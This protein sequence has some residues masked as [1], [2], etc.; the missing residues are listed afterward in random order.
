MA[1]RRSAFLSG[2]LIAVAALAAGMVLASRLD[3]APASFAGAVDVPATNSAPLDGPLDASTFRTIAAQVGPAV[4]SIQ[5]TGRRQ[6]PPTGLEEFFGVPNPF[7]EQDRGQGQGQP[8]V[9]AGSGFIIDADGY[10]LTNRHVI[11]G[12]DTIEVFLSDMDPTTNQPGLPAEVVGQDELVDT[13]LLRLT[14]MPDRP[15]VEA[16]FGDSSQLAAGDWV[17]AIGNPFG[18][19]N[20]VT[21][22]VVSADGRRQ[23]LATPGR[24]ENLIQTDAAI[25]RGNSGGPL[26]NIRGEVVGIN[27]LIYSQTGGNQGIGFAVPINSVAEILPGL[28][29]GRVV[30]GVIGVSVSTGVVTAELAESYGL[31][32][33]GG[34]IVNLVPEGPALDAGIRVDDVIIEYNGTQVT[35]SEQLVALVVRTTPGTTV[36]VKLIRNRREVVVSVTVGELD[37]EAEQQ[38]ANT[39]GPRAPRDEPIETGFGMTLDEISPRIAQQLRLPDGRQGAVVMSVDPTGAAARAG[40]AVGDL[41][42]QVDGREVTSVT[43]AGEALDAVQNGRTAR[44]IIWRRGTEQ[45]I[46]V[47]KR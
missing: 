31:P 21:V 6:Q 32:R 44:V 36:P 18:L 1:T 15:L 38:V 47:P 4:V 29:D 12:A 17:M 40:L 2:A 14:E 42:I 13:A 34:A 27:T 10:I 39:P 16:S 24:F 30:R 11:E 20:T 26:L 23:A 7:G 46:L 28:R 41:V 3:M 43:E 5:T 22:G 25:N 8:T 37:L 9:G 45:L 33:V 19:S 35:D